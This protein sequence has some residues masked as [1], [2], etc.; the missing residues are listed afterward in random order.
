M[1]L[2]LHVGQTLQILVPVRDRTIPCQAV[3]L[4]VG[5]RTFDTSPPHRHGVRVPLELGELRISLTMPDAIYTVTCPLV[6]LTEDGVVF[7]LPDDD[8]VQRVQR[9]NFVRVPTTLDCTVLLWN[10]ETEDYDQP[11]NAE[12][13]DIS[14]GGCSLICGHELKRD[15]E[16]R[17]LIDLPEEGEVL[18]EG[19]VRRTGTQHTRRGRKSSAGVEFGRMDESQRSKLIR[20]VFGVQR[21]QARKAR[22]AKEGL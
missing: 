14:G 3:I 7:E 20:Y 8:A 15:Q 6:K 5:G 9:R 2:P 13:L 4:A 11:F 17:V 19:K 1:K 22:M 16:V 21:E 10:P 12:L 18:L